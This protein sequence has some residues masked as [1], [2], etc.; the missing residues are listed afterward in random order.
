MVHSICT[1]LHMYKQFVMLQRSKKI[2]EKRKEKPLESFE[3]F[4]H[5]QI[6]FL[7]QRSPHYC[8]YNSCYNDL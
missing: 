8:H 2:I 1:K 3:D 6:A 4:D 5:E 7:K